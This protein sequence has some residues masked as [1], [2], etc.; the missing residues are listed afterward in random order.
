MSMHDE[1]VDLADRAIQEIVTSWLA[2]ERDEKALAVAAVD[3]VLARLERPNGEM[4]R[5]GQRSGSLTDDF[6][7]ENFDTIFAAMVRA[8]KGGAA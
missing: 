5:A 3:A 7:L 4:V 8:I 2:D 1:L 6:G